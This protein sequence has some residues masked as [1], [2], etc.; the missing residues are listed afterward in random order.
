MRLLKPTTLAA[1]VLLAGHAA[2]QQPVIGLI[3]KTETNPFFVKMKEGAEAAAKA[4]GAKLLS[5]VLDYGAGQLPGVTPVAGLLAMAR[6][7]REGAP[8]RR[9]AETP[10][11]MSSVAPD[12]GPRELLRSWSVLVT[13]A[14]A[15]SRL[16]LPTPADGIALLLA[17]SDDGTSGSPVASALSRLAGANDDGAAQRA[18]DQLVAL[19]SEAE[20]RDDRAVVEGVA[21]VVVAQVRAVGS[22]PGRLA[23]ERLVRRLQRRRALEIIAQAVP[24][25]IDRLPLLELL[26]RAGE[27][28]VEVLVQQLMIAEDSPSRRSYFDSIVSLDLGATQ[29]F[30][31]VTDP[32]WFVVRTAVAIQRPSSD[33]RNSTG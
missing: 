3:T 12:G 4:K 2:A 25:A 32:R 33:G 10:T 18:A 21:R 29:L 19:I 14:N 7:P 17:P 5:D 11:T 15:P 20:M 22:G 9:P 16:R 1:L 30:G 6:A 31:M 23:L 13:P 27:T 26:A 28:A 24:Q 8:V